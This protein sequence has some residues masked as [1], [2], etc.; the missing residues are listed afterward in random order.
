VL[1]YAI[2]FYGVRGFQRRRKVR[3]MERARERVTMAV[4]KTPSV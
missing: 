2:T 3:L 1:I 4:E